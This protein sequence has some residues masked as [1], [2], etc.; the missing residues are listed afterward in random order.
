MKVNLKLLPCD[1]ATRVCG[2]LPAEDAVRLHGMGA[3]AAKLLSE[4]M[5]RLTCDPAIYTPHELLTATKA[6]RR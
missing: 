4:P 3:A 6:A 5:Q 2:L 1:V